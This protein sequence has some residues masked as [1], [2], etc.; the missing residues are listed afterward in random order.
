MGRTLP[1]KSHAAAAP[2]CCP[3]SLLPLQPLCTGTALAVALVCTCA[4]AVGAAELCH[5]QSAWLLPQPGCACEGPALPGP[6]LS[7][8][9]P[10]FFL[11]VCTFPSPVRQL[12]LWWHHC[13][14][15]LGHVPLRESCRLP[16]K[17]ATGLGAWL[18]QGKSS[19]VVLPASVRV[20]WK[21]SQQ[22]LW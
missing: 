5:P 16:S 15:Q 20:F 12:V 1:F 4:G 7:P 6:A 14:H 3:A 11:G 8:P 21:S 17:A 22:S 18:A 2:L 10:T 9:K 19:I 13:G